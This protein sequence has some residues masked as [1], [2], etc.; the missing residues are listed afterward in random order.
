MKKYITLLTLLLNLSFNQT[1]IVTPKGEGAMGVWGNISKGVD[2]DDDDCEEIFG[3]G[4]SYMM[5]NGVELGINYSTY[6]NEGSDTENT[7]FYFQ[8]HLKKIGKN[9]NS[10]FNLIPNF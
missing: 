6:D 7:A 2:C 5:E 4:I 10:S 1:G 9:L 3:G 8:Y